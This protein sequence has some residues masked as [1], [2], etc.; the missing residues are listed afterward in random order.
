VNAAVRAEEDDERFFVIEALEVGA[1]E[2]AEKVLMETGW[3]HEFDLEFEDKFFGRCRMASGPRERPLQFS[4]F[5][6]YPGQRFQ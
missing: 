5:Y 6:V 2:R 4:C 1:E 3:T